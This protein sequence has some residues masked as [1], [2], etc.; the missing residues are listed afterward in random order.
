VVEHCVTMRRAE[1]TAQA[2]AVTDWETSR[3]LEAL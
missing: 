2:A 1:L 3:Y